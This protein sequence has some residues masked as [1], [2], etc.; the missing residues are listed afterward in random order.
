MGPTLRRLRS[1]TTALAVATA[2]IA[3]GTDGDRTLRPAAPDA[4]S[5]GGSPAD[6]SGGSGQ[7]SGGTGG[8]KA[9][10]TGGRASSEEDAS[11]VSANGGAVQE[12]SGG[13]T[14][15][16]AG[17]SAGG[18]TNVGG[19]TSAGGA[20]QMGGGGSTSTGGA[21]GGSAG[22]TAN[23]KGFQNPA[24][25]TCL[26]NPDG[27]NPGAGVGC[28]SERVAVA[29]ECVSGKCDELWQCVSSTGC[30]L[31]RT[32]VDPFTGMPGLDPRFCYCGDIDPTSFGLCLQAT[33]MSDP[34][35]PHGQCRAVVEKLANNTVPSMV[36][37]VLFDP[38][39]PLGAVFSLMNCANT[40]CLG[41]CQCD[42]AGTSPLPAGVVCGGSGNAGTG[43]TG[44]TGGTSGGAGGILAGN[45]GVKGSG[46]A[47]TG[48]SIGSGGN[49]G[50]TGNGGTTTGSG[51]I[52][53]NGGIAAGGSGGAHT[54]GTSGAGGAGGSNAS[55]CSSC[56]TQK[57]PDPLSQLAAD[58]TGGKCD[59][60]RACIKQSACDQTQADPFTGLLGIDGR[61]CY[62]GVDVDPSNYGLCFQATQS[63]DPN[64]PH[65]PCRQQIETLTGQTVPVNIGTVFF[66]M[67]SPLGAV[68]NLEACDNT[69]C[70]IECCSA[71]KN[72]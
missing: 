49:G 57:C 52:S 4:G 20:T 21:A 60:L 31:S 26:A 58:C 24:C 37:T 28:S 66:D 64:Y 6:E 53:G 42:I 43:G 56:E 7:E 71:C 25:I 70:L 59:A 33:A 47:G 39:G 19:T 72:D 38:A 29:T 41:D 61:N 55:V 2:L 35:Y 40:N 48:G 46:G 54:G 62:C 10:G 45:G 5:S 36:G 32:Q 18:T 51:G 13:S 8:K 50:A 27:A 34:L 44:G 17:T 15:G 11:S 14:S 1:F 3:C 69:A 67:T 12:G 68:M 30:A 22:G 23:S 16:G 9:G 63:S 65:G